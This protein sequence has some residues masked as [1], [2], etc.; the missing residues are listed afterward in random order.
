[1]SRTK[2]ESDDIQHHHKHELHFI[3]LQWLSPESGGAGFVSLGFT[4]IQR[5]DGSARAGTAPEP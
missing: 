1:M 5:R 2:L 3:G 4:S